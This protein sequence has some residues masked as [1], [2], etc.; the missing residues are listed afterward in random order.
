M[1]PHV[2]VRVVIKRPLG[3]K[4]CISRARAIASLH[5]R[6]HSQAGGG[7]GG[8]LRGLLLQREHVH[9][10][11][12]REVTRACACACV[13]ACV[14]VRACIDHARRSINLTNPHTTQ[15]PPPPDHNHHQTKPIV[16]R[17]RPRRREHRRH[18]ARRHLQEEAVRGVAFILIV[19]GNQPGRL[20]PCLSVS[21]VCTPVCFPGW[22]PIPTPYNQA[23]KQ[24][25]NQPPI[26]QTYQPIT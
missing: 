4:R 19:I 17:G 2:S 25:T 15:K 16:V 24:P 26:N 22:T 13:C 7:G 1:R 11:G 9:R 8:G 23:T 12:T 10:Q 21:A 5:T 18:Q 3:F 20:Y 14:C 6:T